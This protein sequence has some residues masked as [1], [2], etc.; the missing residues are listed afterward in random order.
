MCEDPGTTRRLLQFPEGV[1]PHSL[2]YHVAVTMPQPAEIF[3]APVVLLFTLFFFTI[4][5]GQPA[6]G[7]YISLSMHHH[8]KAIIET[9]F[10][11]HI[12]ELAHTT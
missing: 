8:L 12:S 11:T 3:N 7:N 1:M 6:S 5:H 2:L 9:S 10:K 4:D